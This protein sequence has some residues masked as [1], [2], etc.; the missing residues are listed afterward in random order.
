MLL[1]GPQLECADI[2][3]KFCQLGNS[4]MYSFMHTEDTDNF[5]ELL[6]N[7][8][9]NL[10]IVLSNGANGMERVITA[11]NIYPDVP[12]FWISDDKDFGAQ[13]YRLQCNYFMV[14]PITVK[15]LEKAIETL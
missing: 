10:I 15:K 6:V 11:R 2:I 8:S 5:L 13:S 3:S 1:F 7:E 4:K 14:K 9:P 12:L